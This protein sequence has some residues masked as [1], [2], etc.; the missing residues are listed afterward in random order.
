M[1]F[2]TCCFYYDWPLLLLCNKSL[3]QVLLTYLDG[4]EE[5]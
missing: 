2:L 3:F 4:D 5:W 1:G